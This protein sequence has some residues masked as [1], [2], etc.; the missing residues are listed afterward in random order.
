MAFQ[1]VH[2]HNRYYDVDYLASP[3]VELMDVIRRLS[4]DVSSSRRT[5]IYGLLRT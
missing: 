4:R 2:F 3:H 1:R 5:V